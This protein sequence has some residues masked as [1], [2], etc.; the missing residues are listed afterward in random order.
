MKVIAQGTGQALD[1][2]RR[3]DADVVFVH[4]KAAGGEIRCRRFRRET[5][6]RSCTTISSWSGP[7][8]ILPASRDRRTSSPRSRPLKDKGRGLHLARRQVGHALRPSSSSGRSP[9]STSQDGQGPLVQGDRPGHGR[10]AQYRV[11]FQRLC[12][13]R[14][15]HMALVQEQAANSSI[16]VEGDKR[17][18]NQYG[19][20]L[21]NP[22][23]HSQREE[24][25][26]PAIHRLAGFA[27]GPEGHRRLQDQ[28]RAAVLSERRRSRRVARIAE[29]PVQQILT[30]AAGSALWGAGASTGQRRSVAI[31]QLALEAAVF[32]VRVDNQVR[33]GRT[34]GRSA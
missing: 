26:R 34:G 8:A 24:G 30:R 13:G 12:A 23:K 10:G 5:L 33:P 2:G 29:G 6:L 17:L 19:V 25:I 4:A 7:R 21:V 14:S 9:A 27:R 31:D 11:G 15:R 3:G 28:R 20:M 1:T 16:A 32:D 18:F 22:A